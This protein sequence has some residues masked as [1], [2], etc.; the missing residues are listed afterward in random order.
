[1]KSTDDRLFLAPTVVPPVNRTTPGFKGGGVVGGIHYNLSAWK[2]E[3]A[4][5]A[6]YFSIAA[7]PANQSSG[8]SFYLDIPAN[9]VSDREPM[10]TSINEHIYHISTRHY[11]TLMMI[12]CRRV[13]TY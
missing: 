3:D 12:N 8:K 13:V 5:G 10:R 6:S 4:Q 1:M 11:G 9:G 2:R 7:R